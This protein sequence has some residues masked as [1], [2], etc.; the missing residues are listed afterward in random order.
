[1]QSLHEE[2]Q[3]RLAAAVKGLA[4]DVGALEGL[5][6]EHELAPMPRPKWAGITIAPAVVKEATIARSTANGLL[7]TSEQTGDGTQEVLQ[8]KQPLLLG[9]DP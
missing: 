5:C 2:A 4:V 9:M 3:L 7:S 1:M 8:R 6:R